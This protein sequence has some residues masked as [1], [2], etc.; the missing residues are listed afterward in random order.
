MIRNATF[1]AVGLFAVMTSSACATKGYVNRKVDQFVGIERSERVATDS[2]HSRDIAAHGTE[3]AS[4]R[5]DLQSLRTDL[6]G[7]RTEFGARIT[8]MEDQVKFAFPV[9]FGFDDT[10][11]RD[12]DRQMLD[13]FATVVQKYYPGAHITVEGFADPAGSARYNLALSQRRANSVRDYLSTQGLGGEAIKAV[14]YGESRLVK[15]GATGDAPGA[16][17]NRRVVFVVDAVEAGTITAM[18]QQT[19]APQQP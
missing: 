19:P 17:L 3:I 10:S 6:Q 8:A 16:E 18:A 7:L 5:T 2:A 9:H 15:P 14:G 12:Q 4:L 13:R 11:V 1:A